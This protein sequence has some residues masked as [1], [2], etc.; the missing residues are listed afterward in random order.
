MSCRKKIDKNNGSNRQEISCE[1]NGKSD[2]RDIKE[3]GGILFTDASSNH[4][5]GAYPHF[6][7]LFRGVSI[8]TENMDSYTTK[9]DAL[10][11]LLERPLLFEYGRKPEKGRSKACSH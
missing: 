7:S 9:T 4:Y 5:G 10:I 2:L 6:I 1:G 8:S 3:K 11:P